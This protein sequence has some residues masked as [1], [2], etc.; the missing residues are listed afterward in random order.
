[1]QSRHRLEEIPSSDMSKRPEAESFL[2]VEKFNTDIEPCL[3]DPKRALSYQTGNIILSDNHK[4][5]ASFLSSKWYKL[6][7][8]K[9]TI[10][11]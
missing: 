6:D 3:D 10:S 5:K 4:Q 8:P 1:M 2:H 7:W 9:K 11:G